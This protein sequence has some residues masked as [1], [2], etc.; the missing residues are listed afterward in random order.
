L[1]FSVNY[2]SLVP[3][4]SDD[5]SLAIG[6]FTGKPVKP[7]TAL[8]AAPFLFLLSHPLLDAV[9]L[10]V[11]QVINHVSMVRNA[12]NYVNIGKIFQPLA[13]KLRALKAPGYFML[14]G[15]LTKAA[16]ALPGKDYYPVREATVTAH[17]FDWNSPLSGDFS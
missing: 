11:V 16:L 8:L 13:G 9:L 3:A 15:T 7:F 12:I 17:F 5:L 14:P 4:S 10:H 1:K 2:V 6:A